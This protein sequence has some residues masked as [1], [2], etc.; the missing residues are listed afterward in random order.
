MGMAGDAGQETL[1]RPPPIA[2]HDDRDMAWNFN[3]IRDFGG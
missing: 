2:V 3:G 1:F